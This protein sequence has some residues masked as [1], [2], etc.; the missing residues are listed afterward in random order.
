[1]FLNNC[2]SKTILFQQLVEILEKSLIEKEVQLFIN[3]YEY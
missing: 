1:M 3:K 2:N